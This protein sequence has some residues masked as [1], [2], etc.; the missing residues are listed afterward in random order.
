MLNTKDI[1]I[2]YYYFYHNVFSIYSLNVI[3]EFHIASKSSAFVHASLLDIGITKSF[4]LSQISLQVSW[5]IWETV[6]GE[7]RNAYSIDFMLSSLAKYL[8]FV[9]LSKKQLVL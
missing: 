4:N 1:W 6:F 9:T 7:I 2:Y 5:I 3:K 8:K